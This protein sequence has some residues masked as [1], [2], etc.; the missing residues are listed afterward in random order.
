MTFAGNGGASLKDK[1]IPVW[2]KSS[3]LLSKSKSFW[4]D[5]LFIAQFLETDRNTT[6]ESP[7]D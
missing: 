1:S 5:S 2:Q 3:S 6:Q 4:K 7:V